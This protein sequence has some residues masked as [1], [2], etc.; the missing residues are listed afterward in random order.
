[1]TQIEVLSPQE[2]ASLT[3]RVEPTLIQDVTKA[4]WSVLDTD[5]SIFIPLPTE[6]DIAAVR[7]R[8]RRAGAKLI[9]RRVIRNGQEGMVLSARTAR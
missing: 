8:L 6:R 3:G 2:A 1:M 7:M 9:S 5:Q 4:L